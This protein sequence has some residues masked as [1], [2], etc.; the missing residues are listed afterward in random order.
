MNSNEKS[1]YYLEFLII[2]LLLL[3][4]VLIFLIEFAITVPF[5]VMKIAVEN[6]PTHTYTVNYAGG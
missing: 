1:W 2:T 3:F 5:I 6:R 4:G